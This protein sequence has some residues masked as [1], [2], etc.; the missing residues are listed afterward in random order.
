MHKP[1]YLARQVDQTAFELLPDGA[2]TVHQVRQEPIRLAPETVHAIYL[3]LRMPGVAAVL[4]RL[5]AE[6][7][8]RIYET[9][10]GDL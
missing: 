2:L 1:L 10:Y 7:Q 5:D 6:R 9:R 8:I 3:L 4:R